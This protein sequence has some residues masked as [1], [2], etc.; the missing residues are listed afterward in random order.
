MQL[1]V[2]GSLMNYGYTDDALRIAR[3]F[4]TTVERCF[5][6]TGHLWEKYNIVNG[7]TEA[8]NEYDMPAMMGWSAGVYLAAKKFVDD[9][10]VS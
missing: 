7:T 1:M 2:A 9:N 8:K 6:S 4:K 5:A 10:A 3:K